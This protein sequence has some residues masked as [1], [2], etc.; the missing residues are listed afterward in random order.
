MAG[1]SVSRYGP[2]ER[3][4]WA[5]LTARDSVVRRLDWPLLGSSLAL[6][7]VGSLLVW[8]A[9]RGRDSLTHGDP[10][11][12]LFRHALNTGIGLAL[13]IG[14]IWLGHRTLRGAVPVLYGLS[15]L[16]VLA[17]L[18]PLGATVNGAHAWILLPGGFSSSPPSSPRSRSSSAWRCCS[19]PA[20]TRVTSCTPTTGPSPR[21]SDWRSSRWPSSC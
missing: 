1:F 8:S 21:R 6:S 14:T 3:S 19:P 7:F 12:F 2:E 13:M 4:V 5:R 9:T 20:S 15:V 18:T 11:F 10:Y 16:L 17:V